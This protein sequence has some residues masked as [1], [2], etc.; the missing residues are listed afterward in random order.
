MRSARNRAQETRAAST[1]AAR[2]LARDRLKKETM[3]ST[4]PERNTE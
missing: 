1:A 4:G 3:A 2:G